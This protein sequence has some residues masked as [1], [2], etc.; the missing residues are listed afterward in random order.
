MKIPSAKLFVTLVLLVGVPA[1]AQIY[2]CTD[3]EGRTSYHQVPCSSGETGG[4]VATPAETDSRPPS[5]HQEN[6]DAR[7]LTSLVAGALAKRDYK[8]AESLAVTREHHEMIAAERK[9]ER[10]EKL[11]AQKARP[12]NPTIFVPRPI[13]VQQPVLQPSTTYCDR[14][15]ST[16]SCRSY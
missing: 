5:T 9:R 4:M 13:I 1:Q 10:E 12:A 3:R 7:Y 11:A 2:K 8:H 15:G 6:P 16:V 14:L